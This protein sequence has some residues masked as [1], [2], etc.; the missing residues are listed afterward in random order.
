MPI[1]YLF[2]DLLIA[3]MVI[4][5]TVQA[6]NRMTP[7]D[8]PERVL[9]ARFIVQFLGQHRAWY[10]PILVGMTGLL[11]SAFLYVDL[12]AS[13]CVVEVCGLILAL[14]QYRLYKQLRSPRPLHA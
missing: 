10:F 8:G 5:A 6:F 14:G 3:S 9:T 7:Q 11:A 2:F 12:F 13:G 4:F 1:T